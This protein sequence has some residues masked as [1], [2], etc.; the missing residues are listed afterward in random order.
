MLRSVNSNMGILFVL[1]Y[2]ISADLISESLGELFL[3]QG[4]LY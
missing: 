4:P 1:R 2:A 3:H